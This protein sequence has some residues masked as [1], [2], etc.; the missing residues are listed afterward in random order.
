MLTGVDTQAAKCGERLADTRPPHHCPLPFVY[1]ANG[2]ET[3]FIDWLD[4][5]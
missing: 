4:S 5:E 1:Q 2:L 3:R